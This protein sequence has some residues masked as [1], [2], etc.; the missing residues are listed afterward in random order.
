MTNPSS[1]LEAIREEIESNHVESRYFSGDDSSDA[2]VWWQLTRRSREKIKE[3]AGR[4]AREPYLM[5]SSDIQSLIGPYLNISKGYKDDWDTYGGRSG[6][7]ASSFLAD[8]LPSLDP[9][10]IQILKVGKSFT[11]DLDDAFKCP[12]LEDLM[13][14]PHGYIVINPEKRRDFFTES[15]VRRLMF[16]KGKHEVVKVVKD[17]DWVL[18]C[19]PDG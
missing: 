2:A 15:V 16:R 18:S 11:N 4:L 7:R 19:L 1:C 6:F 9:E 12:K 8:V 14:K 5:T 17:E 10:G 3:L 13:S